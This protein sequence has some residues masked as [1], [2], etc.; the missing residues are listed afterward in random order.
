M[1]PY[2]SEIKLTDLKHNGIER[3]RLYLSK[4]IGIDFGKFGE[5]WPYLQ[6]VNQIRNLIVHSGGKLPSDDKHN[7]YKIIARLDHLDKNSVGYL[8]IDSGFIDML[9]SKLR[10][11]FH[12]LDGE[13]SKYAQEYVA[14][15]V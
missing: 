10:T 11:F 3:A 7:I 14:R 13:V 1:C 4:M 2:D 6:D 5:S 12:T 15:T 8:S 9:I